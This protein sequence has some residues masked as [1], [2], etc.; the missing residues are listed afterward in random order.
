MEVEY[1][2]SRCSGIVLSLLSFDSCSTV[3]T[4]LHEISAKK[5][6]YLQVMELPQTTGSQVA[7]T[8]FLNTF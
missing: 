6:I 7:T 2:F 4:D 5:I 8:W 3:L 1:K